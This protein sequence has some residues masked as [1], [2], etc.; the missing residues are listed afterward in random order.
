MLVVIWSLALVG[1][2][3]SIF[4]LHLPRWIVIALYIGMGWMSLILLPHVAQAVSLQ[5]VLWLLTGGYST[6]LA[7]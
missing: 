3:C 2:V 7:Q 5:P 1:M 4:T 6:R